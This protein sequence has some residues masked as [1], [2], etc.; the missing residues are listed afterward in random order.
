MANTAIKLIDIPV[1]NTITINSKLLSVDSNTKRTE[2][3]TGYDLTM[4][5]ANTVLYKD[6]V[7]TT[8][9]LANTAYI[10]A[11]SAYQYANTA[12][13]NA[14]IA[15]DGSN[16]SFL[17]SNS[18]YQQAN[19]SFN[20]ANSAF[21]HANLSFNQANSAFNHANLSFNQANSAYYAANVAY[22]VANSVIL[23]SSY[24]QVSSDANLAYSISNFAY[25]QANAA[26]S[27]ANLK[28]N[29]S[30]GII[31]G[32]VEINSS[33]VVTGNVTFSGNVTTV[34]ANNLTVQDNMI[35][36]NEGLSGNTNPDL[37]I[38]GAYDDGIYHH[39][40]IFRD[41]T[42]GIWKV[43][44]N[45]LPEPDE[46]VW[47]DTSNSSFRIANFQAN[48]LYGYTNASTIL[49]GTVPTARLGSGTANAT[50][51]LAGDNS[52]KVISLTNIPNS[53]LSNSS[54]TING[55]AISL[56]SS[57][58]VTAAAGTLTG[59]TLASGVTGSSLT[60]VGTITSGT[61]SGSFGAVSGANL[62]TLNANNISSGTV[63]TARIG[64]GT[65]NA[66]TYLAGDNS[67]KVISLTNIPNSSLANSSVTIN[68]TAISLGSSGTVTAAA[69]TLTGSTLASGV[70]GSSLTSVGT[71]TSG[72]WSG[73][74]GAVSGANLTTLNA[75]NL[76]SGTVATARLGSGTANASTYLAGDNS[77]KVLTSSSISATG[78]ATASTYLAGDNSWKTISGFSTA[79]DTSTD[80]TYYPTFVTTAGGSTAKTSSTKLYFNPSTGTL[81][82]TIFNSLSDIEL[83]TNV[84]D[85]ESGL[86]II[87]KINPVEFEWKDNGKKSFGVIAQDIEKILPDLVSTAENKSVNYSGLIAFLI[88]SVQELSAKI[89]QIEESNGN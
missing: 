87:E 30:G 52:W 56:G 85:I 47:I 31:S 83:K 70:T 53:S 72:T 73:S 41:A 49:V 32:P 67:W 46:S 2:L 40:G 64:S 76:A 77:W 6:Q 80:S 8:F 28:F 20:Q 5:L 74:F 34:S 81:S 17:Q 44:D 12:L 42:D 4:Y 39:T 25:G 19:L 78:T 63:A 55:T 61:W 82:A 36:L 37:G 54:V 15:Y 18:A 10:L 43:F 1:S 66:S 21:N 29:S 35:Y 45:Y 79:D 9:E 86:D 38:V 89:K 48:N 33:L 75:S 24:E 65:A 62:T 11:N 60:S 22:E 50:T 57:D 88:K 51:Y 27:T 84:I 68:G 58:N 69:G 3:I 14:T 23:L 71:V 59:S 16:T 26:Y 7:N 13:I